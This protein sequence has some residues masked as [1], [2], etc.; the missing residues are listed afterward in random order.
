MNRTHTNNYNEQI[1]ILGKKATI[2]MASSNTSLPVN[3]L[4][5]VVSGVSKYP[6]VIF[7][8]QCCVHCS[9]RKSLKL[10]LSCTCF[11]HGT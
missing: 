5:P 6:A 8:N 7:K 1:Q 9:T 4:E 11:L 3:R 10:K 2:A